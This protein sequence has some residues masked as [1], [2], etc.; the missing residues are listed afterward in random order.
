MIYTN[1]LIFIAAIAVYATASISDQTVVSPVLGVYGILFALL[2]FWNFNRYKFM[3]LR[4][5]LQDEEIGINE[6]KRRFHNTIN[7]HVIFSIFFFAV[8][9]YGFE[10]KRLLVGT[11]LLGSLE[12]YVNAAGLAF[13]M[14]HLGF[15]WYWAH[16][17]MGNSL[18]L[19]KSAG[20]YIRS[21]IKFN[22][23]IVIPWLLF[24]LVLDLVQ[25]F[26][27]GFQQQMAESMLLQVAFFGL[28]L[29]VVSIFA[30]VLIV[31]LWDCK[32]LEDIELRETIAAFCR[33][34][35]VKF[36][37][38]MSWNALNGG[39]TTAGVI[40]LFAPFRYLMLTP[41]LMRLLDRDE[42]LGVV[43]HE[44]GHVKKKHLF[45]YLIFFLG[46]AVLSIGII[47]YIMVV[48]FLFAPESLVVPEFF[49]YFSIFIP[50]VLLIV[51]FRFI[52]GYFM[53]N[54]ERQA[55]TYC[56]ES[57]VDPNHLV[58]SFMK[59]GVHVG[60]DGKKSNWH[61]YN[62]SQRIGFIRDCMANP[63]EI[64]KHNRKLKRSLAVFSTL[65]LVVS[66]LSFYMPSQLNN[67]MIEKAILQ[68][69]EEEPENP[70]LY[71]MLG[72]VSFQLEKWP[73]VKS[74]YEKA[75][76]LDYNQ[77]DVLNNLAWLYLTCPDQQIHNPRRALELAQDAVKL[78]QR[79]H[80]LDTLAE[81]YFQNSMYKE[82]Y[83]A[84][85]H[86]YL[87]ATENLKYFKKQLK[88]MQKYY[89]TFKKMIKI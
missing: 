27:P 70:R 3:K 17:A 52:F 66:T 2:V 15:V 36:K 55:D 44:V 1:F 57:G 82:A 50:I 84:A 42:L 4:R 68:R 79:A 54:F 74:A 87:R 76:D 35:G 60:D 37:G 26:A 38:I 73:E 28:F 89:N 58:T 9:I 88:K 20:S 6:A 49:N 72:Q 77:S 25:T 14:L 59:L 33:S 78:E 32:P 65:L 85:H 86:A 11:P 53:R 81:A 64:K 43:S 56:F 24:I 5:Q 7:L 23:V 10:L 19:G 75:L 62:I 48:V 71:S 30:P 40:G 22:I 34:Q 61:H 21:N 80:T 46:F 41:D 45:Y 18:D 12:T 51:Y 8:E 16:K 39:L 31:R 63:G 29:L 13:F 67:Q 69:I 83:L 47:Q